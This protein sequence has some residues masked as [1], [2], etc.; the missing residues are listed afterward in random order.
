MI[1]PIY[2]HLELLI[3]ASTAGSRFMILGAFFQSFRLFNHLDLPVFH[4]STHFSP[5]SDCG[6]IQS[7]NLHEM[8]LALGSVKSPPN[9]WRSIFFG[10]IYE[11]SKQKMQKQMHGLK[12]GLLWLLP[13]LFTY[14][15]FIL[16]LLLFP[17]VFMISLMSDPNTP[18][19]AF[20]GSP[21][22]AWRQIPW[23][24]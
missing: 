4:M 21:F 5:T 13:L 22:F 3:G 24:Q 8:L 9:L 16:L 6:K 15:S 18:M 11:C 23:V 17:T 7:C 14:Y 12:C 10:R 20:F 1:L 19:S 2:N